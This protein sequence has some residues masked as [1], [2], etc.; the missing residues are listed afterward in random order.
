MLHNK[1]W[2]GFF[3]LAPIAGLVLLF[4]GYAVFMFT[5]FGNIEQFEG[6]DAPPATFFGGLGVFIAMVL[7]MVLVSLGSLVFYI[8][9]AVKNPNLQHNNLLLVW[10]LLF[11]FA[12]GI[13]Q[14]IYWVVEILGNRKA[15][16]HPNG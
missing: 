11:I 1:F 5:L 6:Q 13:G 15:A 12:N 16:P 14:V 3:A 9:H 2:Q 10:I 7:L 8:V 4:A